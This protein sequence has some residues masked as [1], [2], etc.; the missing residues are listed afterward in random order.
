M[1]NIFGTLV[2]K[3]TFLSHDKFQSNKEHAVVFFVEISPRITLRDTLRE[4]IQDA[5]MWSDI[6]EE[7]SKLMIHEIK[8][9]GG[10]ST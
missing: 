9:K 6:D 4:T 5:L 2:N 10:L 7:I 8:K 3:N 1:S